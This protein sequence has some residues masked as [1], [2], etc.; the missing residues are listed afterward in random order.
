MVQGSS[1]QRTGGPLSLDHTYEFSGGLSLAISTISNREPK[2]YFSDNRNLFNP[3]ILTLREAIFNE[4][5]TRLWN[6]KFLQGM[7]DSGES[8][9]KELKDYVG[10]LLGWNISKPSEIPEDFWQKTFEVYFNDEYK[11]G[12][13]KFFN[14]KEPFAYQDVAGIMLETM[15]KGYW[16]PEIETKDKIMQVYVKLAADN[17][18]SCSVRTCANPKVNQ[19]VENYFSHNKNSL[20]QLDFKRYQNNLRATLGEKLKADPDYG[21]PE[22]VVLKKI[23]VIK[24]NVKIE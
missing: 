10:N 20:S 18:L 14:E 6:P 12:V 5:T 24:K 7:M 11:I 19:F 2:N 21:L 9:G 23:N 22:E 17:G 8:G 13:D 4:A 1:S 15:R 16:H 3:Q